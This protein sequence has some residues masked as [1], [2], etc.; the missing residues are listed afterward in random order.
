MNKFFILLL[1]LLVSCN[2]KA[3]DS[4]NIKLLQKAYVTKDEKVFLENF[5]ENFKNFKSTFG[6]NDK[7]DKPNVLYDVSNQY[8]DYLFELASEPKFNSY[9][10]KIINI[11]IDGKWE[12]DGVGYFRHK[13]H[14]L[15]ET[16]KEFILLLNNLNENNINSFWRFYFDAEDLIYSPKLEVILDK[17]MKS[18]AML[19]FKKLKKERKS[20]NTLD[21]ILN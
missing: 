2:N 9:K 5:P 18:K 13:L 20:E 19:V 11:A 3:Q 21:H 8:I 10:K 16:D 6:W 14:A 15:I 4:N 1:L 12:A 7:L 17:S